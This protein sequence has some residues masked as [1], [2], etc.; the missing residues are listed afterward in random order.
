MIRAT[1]VLPGNLNLSVNGRYVS[2][3]YYD[4]TSDISRSIPSWFIAG[5]NLSREFS[6]NGRGRIGASFYIDNLFNRKIFLQWLGLYRGFQRR[7][8]LY[9][10][11]GFILRQREITL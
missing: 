2:K 8:S 3:Q 9:V 5:I 1:S 6:L 4:N 10:E 7:L 11:E